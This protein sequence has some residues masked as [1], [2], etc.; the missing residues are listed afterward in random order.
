MRKTDKE[1]SV[2]ELRARLQDNSIAILAK[3]Q[4]INVAQATELRRKLRESGVEF[5]VYKNTLARIVLDEL[6]FSPAAAFME[7]PTAW[8]FS[9]DP[10][11]PARLLRD[12]G[13]DVQFV[14][15]SGGILD[16]RVMGPDKLTALADLPSKDEL[17]AQVVG[18]IAQPLRAAVGAISAL[19]RN[20]ASV[21]DQIRK[22][23]EEAGEAA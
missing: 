14:S 15:M 16:G 6:G 4:G 3:Y 12:F 23:K 18:T 20:L 1:A 9:K 13:K 2:A 11:T 19:P 8:A 22:Q 21:I 10:V 5:K 7:G 17:R